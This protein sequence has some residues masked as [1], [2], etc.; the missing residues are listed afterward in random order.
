MHEQPMLIWGTIKM[1]ALQCASP[2][3]QP[4][5][6]HL[7]PHVDRHLAAIKCQ[8]RAHSWALV[9]GI[10]GQHDA[11]GLTAMMQCLAIAKPTLTS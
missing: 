8:H 10:L 4:M 1:Q 7:E 2:A 9:G 3:M 5:T 6:V 11:G